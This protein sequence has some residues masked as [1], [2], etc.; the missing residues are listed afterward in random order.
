M[1]K[2]FTDKEIEERLKKIGFVQYFDHEDD[3]DPQWDEGKL[4]WAREGF[5][6][7]IK[8]SENK[9]MHLLL[10][11]ADFIEQQVGEFNLYGLKTLTPTKLENED[12]IELFLE[13]RN[14]KN[15]ENN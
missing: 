1:S 12:L 6:E 14:N 3:D 8:F 7:G 2:L 10:E 4:H 15:D 5:G 9:T 11:F 13:E